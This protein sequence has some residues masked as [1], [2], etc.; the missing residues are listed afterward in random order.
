MN[1]SHDKFDLILRGGTVYDGSGGDPFAADVGITGDRI[2]ALGVL[3]GVT[4]S[5]EIDVSGMA[6]SPGFIDAHS[7]DDFHV[8]S[9]PD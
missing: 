7:H 9:S 4:A 1:T 3:S 6:V 2:T 5:D 8:L